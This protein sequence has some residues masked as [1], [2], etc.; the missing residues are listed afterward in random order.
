[1]NSFEFYGVC[2][3]SNYNMGNWIKVV[4]CQ[5]PTWV[6]IC[7]SCGKIVDRSFIFN[8]IPNIDPSIVNEYAKL[9]KNWKSWF[10]FR[11]KKRK[12]LVKFMKC[13]ARLLKINEKEIKNLKLKIKK[14]EVNSKYKSYNGKIK[15]GSYSHYDRTIYIN[16]KILNDLKKCVEVIAHELTHCKQHLEVDKFDSEEQYGLT[17]NLK[18]VDYDPLVSVWKS[19]FTFQEKNEFENY[20]NQYVEKVARDVAEKISSIIFPDH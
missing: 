17:S 7:N 8:S 13:C 20:Y 16:P 12:H 10:N 15:R 2:N 18:R 14:L 9:K 11:C 6:V 5:V 3:C 4:Y 19:E 1:L